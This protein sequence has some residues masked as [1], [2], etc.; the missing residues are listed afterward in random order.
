M[1]WNTHLEDAPLNQ[2]I[3]LK[4]KY[5]MFEYCTVGQIYQYKGERFLGMQHPTF[6]K[7]IDED[8]YVRS[9]VLAWKDID[10]DAINL[11]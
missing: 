9:Q 2:F 3:M 7:K 5:M 8:T 4:M 10:I 11:L 6:Q 1:Q